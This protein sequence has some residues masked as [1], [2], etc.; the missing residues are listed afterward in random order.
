MRLFL[1]LF[2]F[3][4]LGSQ[5]FTYSQ[6]VADTAVYKFT[7]VKSL[8]ATSVKDQGKSGT[9]WC[10]STISMIESELMRMGKGEQNLSEMFVVRHTYDGKAERYIRMHG[11]N[12]FSE[13]AEFND[14][15]NSVKTYGIVPDSVYTGF[16]PNQT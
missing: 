4:L 2:L 7:N 10:F 12:S 1:I 14:V 15:M 3:T 6:Q 13:G 16:R 8:K 9:C 5:N 11:S